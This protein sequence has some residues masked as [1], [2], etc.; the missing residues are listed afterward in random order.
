MRPAMVFSRGVA[1]GVLILLH[2]GHSNGLLPAHPASKLGAGGFGRG[3]TGVGEVIE[4]ALLLLLALAPLLHLLDGHWQ[5][6]NLNMRVLPCN[7]IQLV[8][9][10]LVNL[11]QIIHTEA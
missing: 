6:S 2:N 5:C 9:N 7:L 4:D 10:G 8:R 3:R 11:L 1:E